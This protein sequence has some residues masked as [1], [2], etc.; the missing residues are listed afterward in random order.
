MMTIVLDEQGEIDMNK[1]IQYNIQPY[2]FEEPILVE[3]MKDIE[4]VYKI[5]GL[6]FYTNKFGV[7]SPSDLSNGMKALILLTCQGMGKGKD[8]GLITN[9]CMGGNCIKYLCQLSLK[10]DFRLE[11]DYPTPCYDNYDCLIKIKNEDKIYTKVRPAFRE[12]I[13]RG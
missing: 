4:D 9:S 3:A 12:A 7:K 8:I 10:Y 1:Y 2:L 13:S 5:E 6:A 11:W